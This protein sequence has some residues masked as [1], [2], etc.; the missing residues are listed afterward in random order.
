MQIFSRLTGRGR[1]YDDLSVSIQE[2]IAERTEEL[3]EEEGMPRAQA[4]QT[5]RRGFG[6]LTQG[7]ERSRET[8]QWSALESVLA[9]LKLTVR[10]L[11]K[12][13]GFTPTV[14]LTLAIEIGANTTVS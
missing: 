14:L 13:P 9:D 11:R 12:S 10:R 8:W 3:I 6:N 2:H 1:R 5:A 7:T 4:E